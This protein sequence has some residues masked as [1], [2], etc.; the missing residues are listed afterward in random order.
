MTTRSKKPNISKSNL[1]VVEALI[2]SRYFCRKKDSVP[3]R[4]MQLYLVKARGDPRV[5]LLAGH[6]GG[7]SSRAISSI[8][9]RSREKSREYPSIR[10]ILGGRRAFR[11]MVFLLSSVHRS[12]RGP[13]IYIIKLFAM[14]SLT[15]VRKSI[16]TSCMSWTI[17][18]LEK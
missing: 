14:S 2:K 16:F 17:R 3:Y 4:R 9:D 8:Q 7:S 12:A 10:P 6:I 1:W 13:L 5:S 18:S 15:V 11:C